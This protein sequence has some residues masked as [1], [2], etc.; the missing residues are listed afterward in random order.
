ME[1]LKPARRSA[2]ILQKRSGIS[3]LTLALSRK[4]SDRLLTAA[5]L[6][7]VLPRHA[8]VPYSCATLS[9][10]RNIKFDRKMKGK[11]F[12]GPVPKVERLTQD[13]ATTAVTA[14]KLTVGNDQDNA[15]YVSLLI[16]QLV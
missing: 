8:W 16:E 6:W 5:A 4:L 11:P 13:E 3:P 9:P 14:A 2:Q 10:T 12:F 15:S 1:Q 7:N